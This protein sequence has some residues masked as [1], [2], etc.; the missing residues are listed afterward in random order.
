MITFL[1]YWDESEVAFVSRC[2]DVMLSGKWISEREFIPRVGGTFEELGALRD[3][4]MLLGVYSQDGRLI[5][6]VLNEIYGGER[7]SEEKWNSLFSVPR[8]E[9]GRIHRKIP[10]RVLFP[11]R[12]LH[13]RP[14]A[15]KLM[16]MREV[17]R[18]RLEAARRRRPTGAEPDSD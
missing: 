7:V 1:D 15:A 16:R 10:R 2:I 17:A 9:A 18:R 8:S 13:L 14:D 5:L 11:Q 12:P 3:S 4:W 6:A